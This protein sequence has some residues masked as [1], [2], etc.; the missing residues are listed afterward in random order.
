MH[1]ICQH[2]IGQISH[3]VKSGLT[4]TRKHAIPTV[5]GSQGKYWL[6]SDPNQKAEDL[7]NSTRSFGHYFSA[8]C[9]K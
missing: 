4:R 2:F 9:L 8:K 3:T 1:H 7:T 5:L 6:S